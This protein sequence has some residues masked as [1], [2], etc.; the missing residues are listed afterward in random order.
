MDQDLDEWL[1]ST[2]DLTEV[3]IKATVETCLTIHVQTRGQLTD[4]LASNS[5]SNLFI[6]DAALR[7][8][9]H[10]LFPERNAI[11]AV[12][13]AVEHQASAK[14][15]GEETAEEDN[16]LFAGEAAAAA[17]AEVQ[18]AEVIDKG[19]LTE[20]SFEEGLIGLGL[21][22][23]PSGGGFEI[24][25]VLDHGLAAGY[26]Y[27]VGDTLLAINGNFVGGMANVDE[28]VQLMT[29]APRPIIL[30]IVKRTHTDAPITMHLERDSVQQN[31]SNGYGGA[32]FPYKTGFSKWSNHLYDCTCIGFLG[33]WCCQSCFFGL[34]ASSIPRYP[35]C[36]CAAVG[37]FAIQFLGTLFLELTH[38]GQL[39]FCLN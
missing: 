8:Q 21:C 1:R 17:T 19:Q 14:D 13:H 20:P 5:V 28:V 16:K 23:F 25:E 24:S 6:E 36:C 27:S 33:S 34:L 2:T 15:D 30:S 3:K 32:F 22:A 26:G 37:Y 12:T 39:Y 7:E 35:G 4:Y 10:K 18:A 38:T 31:A 9:F 29:S 11:T